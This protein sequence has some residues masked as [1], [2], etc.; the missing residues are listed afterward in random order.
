MNTHPIAPRSELVALASA[1]LLSAALAPTSRAQPRPTASQTATARQCAA[2]DERAAAWFGHSSR[3]CDRAALLVRAADWFTA[4][5]LDEA[6]IHP[7]VPAPSDADEGAT[8][9]WTY[10]RRGDAIFACEGRTCALVGSAPRLGVLSGNASV[11]LYDPASEREEL[12]RL[13]RHGDELRV[14]DRAAITF[15]PPPAEMRSRPLPR[16]PSPLARREAS[17]V[18]DARSWAALEPVRAALTG[19]DDWANDGQIVAKTLLER[20]T[21]RITLLAYPDLDGGTSLGLVVVRDGA[22]T[23]RSPITTAAAARV[24]EVV[25]DEAPFVVRTRYAALFIGLEG[26]SARFTAVETQEVV[27]AQSVDCPSPSDPFAVCTHVQLC[28]RALGWIDPTH[29]RLG[30]E[31]R[32]A[33]RRGHARGSALRP[34]RYLDEEELE[35]ARCPEPRELR[36]VG[37]S[38]EELAR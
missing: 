31:E 2:L 24:V 30:P 34:T 29:A 21:L 33:W 37:Q 4:S 5:G 14:R 16:G 20:G 26:A 25:R 38:F 1:L 23:L 8:S 7:S 10:V 27:P 36:L 11:G 3:V 6:S 19:A 17:D 18:Q 13:V 32:R 12:V 15:P 28:A 9:A 22:R 35:G